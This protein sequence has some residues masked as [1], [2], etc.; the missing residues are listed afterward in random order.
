[1]KHIVLVI[2]VISASVIA[3]PPAQ[4]EQEASARVAEAMPSISA[5]P[6]DTPSND[7][8]SSTFDTSAPAPTA[9]AIPAR[10]V[11]K[12]APALVVTVTDY[13][14]GIDTLD[15]LSGGNWLQKRVIWE[16]AQKEYEKIKALF[17]QVLE[18]RIGFYDKRSQSTRDLNVFFAEIGTSRGAL[19][20]EIGDLLARLDQTQA[21]TGAL[22]EEERNLRVKLQEK[23]RELEQLGTDLRSLAEFDTALDTALSQMMQ[24]ISLAADYDRQ[25]WQ[26]FKDIGQEL[27]DYKAKSYYAHM[28]TCK[29]NLQNILTYF[30]GAFSQYLDTV[31]HKMDELR[32]NSKNQIEALQREG[33]DLTKKL[34][35]V[36]EA[37]RKARELKEQEE[38]E[39]Q[40]RLAR[41]KKKGWYNKISFLWEKPASLAQS[42]WKGICSVSTVTWNWAASWF[43]KKAKKPQVDQHSEQPHQD[44]QSESTHRDHSA[45]APHT[46][47]PTGSV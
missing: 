34:S 5:A 16:D 30:H 42:A 24:Q 1:M 36:Q 10:P 44:A 33:L 15:V 23:K 20:D 9:P 46:D 38:R 26:R 43:G 37:E 35:E 14:Q 17:N 29:Q 6:H 39:E 4:N 18:T 45:I 41:A 22:S 8:A 32:T 21:E 25:A 40:E 3:G 19:M 7:S 13:G 47:L 31:V 2:G 11:K 12:T 27:D 28:L